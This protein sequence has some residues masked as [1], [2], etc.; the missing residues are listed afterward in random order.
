MGSFS[1]ECEECG[2]PF[3]VDPSEASRGEICFKCHIQGIGWSVKGARGTSQSFHDETIKEVQDETVQGAAAQGR[4][5]RPK[6]NVYY[7]K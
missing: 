6:T 4:E 1:F 2:K 7:G 3:R 5:V